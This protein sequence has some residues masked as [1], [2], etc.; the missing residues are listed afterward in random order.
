MGYVYYPE[1][2]AAF[3]ALVVIDGSGTAAVVELGTDLYVE[4]YSLGTKV[5]MTLTTSENGDVSMFVG[6]DQCLYSSGLTTTGGQ[7]GFVAIDSTTT[8]LGG[9]K[10]QVCDGRWGLGGQ[11]GGGREWL[12]GFEC[13]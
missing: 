11:A 3:C 1:W 5:S 8:V 4:R 13:A 12:S 9:N 2:A 6:G 7:A 10:A